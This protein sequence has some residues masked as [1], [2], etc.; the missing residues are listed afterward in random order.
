VWL[1]RFNQ[2]IVPLARLLWRIRVFGSGTFPPSGP[3]IIA[4][5]HASYLDPWL[6]GGFAPRLPIR[7][8]MTDAWYE[9]SR[10]WNAAFR[11]WGAIPTAAGRPNVTIDRVV[12]ALNRG[13]IVGVFPEGRISR[14]GSMSRARGGIGFMAARSGAPVVPCGIRGSFQMLPRHRRI[15]RIARVELHFGEPMC[16]DGAPVSTVDNA[17]A[18]RFAQSVVSRIAVLAGVDPPAPSASRQ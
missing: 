14:N 11:S 2:S 6:I 15:P 1:Y 4:A 17:T 3:V 12:A 5:N 13:S 7:F 9:R 10:I 16:F 8:L 18:L